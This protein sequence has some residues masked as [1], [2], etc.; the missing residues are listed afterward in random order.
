MAFKGW[1]IKNTKKAALSSC[2]INSQ[3][4]GYSFKYKESYIEWKDWS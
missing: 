2:D 1:H 3:V 4:N